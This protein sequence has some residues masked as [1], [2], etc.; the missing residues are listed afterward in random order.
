MPIKGENAVFAK[1]LPKQD[2][3]KALNFDSMTLKIANFIVT[4]I[5]SVEFIHLCFIQQYNSIMI[6][7][8]RQLYEH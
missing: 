6:T 2:G 3:K 8:R 4:S 7:K 1:V 5:K